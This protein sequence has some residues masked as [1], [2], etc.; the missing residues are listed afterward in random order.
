MFIKRS[1]NFESQLNCFFSKIDPYRNS[2][3]QVPP[4]LIPAKLQAAW[5]L[6]TKDQSMAWPSLKSGI[7]TTLWEL[8][9][10]WKIR[11]DN[12]TSVW[13]NDSSLFH[14]F[15]GVPLSFF[16]DC[17]GTQT[18]FWHNLLAKHWV[19]SWLNEWLLKIDT[20]IEAISVL[21]ISVPPFTPQYNYG[22][23]I[24]GVLACDTWAKWPQSPYGSVVFHHDCDWL[25][26]LAEK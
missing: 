11:L 13:L 9:S 18:D 21:Q 4:T 12:H 16:L 5:K 19:R 10:L 17:Q 8:K 26:G 14:N 1:L 2:K 24:C 20:L 25:S 7:L 6:N 3:H 23:L 15:I 22:N